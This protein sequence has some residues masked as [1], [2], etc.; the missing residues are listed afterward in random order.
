[1]PSEAEAREALEHAER[2]VAG[3]QEMLEA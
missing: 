3:V 2:F 1:M